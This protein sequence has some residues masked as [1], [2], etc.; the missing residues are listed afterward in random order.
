MNVYGEHYRTIWIKP[1]DCKVV[2]LIDQ[3]VLPHEFL[4]VDITTVEDIAVAIKEM[5][6]RGAGLIGAA[7]GYGMYLGTFAA[8]RS[9]RCYQ[10]AVAQT[11]F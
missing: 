1:D 4:V 5:W 3:R 9:S 10:K 6:V 2:Q 8:P 7:A 11:H